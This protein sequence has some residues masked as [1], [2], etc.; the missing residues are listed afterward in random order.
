MTGYASG[1][2]RHPRQTALRAVFVLSLLAGLLPQTGQ[3]VP[4]T[5]V[6]LKDIATLVGTT[7]QKLMGY[8]L[9]VGLDG[10][11]DSTQSVLTA[12]AL[13]NMLEHF[14][15]RLQPSEVT[16]ENVAAV[17]VT[18]AL[19]AVA[20]EGDRLDLTVASVGDAKSLYGGIL[21]PT[22]LRGDDG[23][24]YALGQGAVSIGGMNAKAGG[25]SV[26]KN[27]A[28]TGQAPAAGT[29]IKA[30]QGTPT[31]DRLQFSLR[32]PD[33]TTAS[34]VAQAINAQ[35][36]TKGARP[37]GP[38]CV[39]VAVPQERRGDVVGLIA[40]LESLS[41]VGD[42]AARVV[43]NE[44]TGTIIIGGDVR[45]LPVA[46]AHGGLTITV[47]SGFE[48]SQP[49]PFSGSTTVLESAAGKGP[50][51][52]AAATP[53][54]VAPKPTGSTGVASAAKPPTTT[55]DLPGARTVVTPRT[56]LK[57]EEP[58]SSLVE[59]H[60]QT[61]LSD[62]VEALNGLGVKPRD[63]VAILQALKTAGALQAELV[64]M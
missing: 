26:Q 2:A 33:F 34:R 38:E 57:V 1:K 37:V 50:T 53:A 19:P 51:E 59:L 61:R 40:E 44:R 6:R 29:V 24:V 52:D 41:V 3:A 22:P 11:G 49:P 64:L 35:L 7:G 9:V 21:L 32:D 13:A 10:T 62:L 14:D 18:A 43:V 46:V 39:E 60:P 45:I 15:L 36:G 56:D 4:S 55:P 23:N 31:T 42:T 16:T 8:G 47:S 48:V 27:H 28:L 54:E 12:Q 30:V 58:A 20:R 5:A 17:M 25:Q 63:L